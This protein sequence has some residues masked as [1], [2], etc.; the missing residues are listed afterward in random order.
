M[1]TQ[2]SSD[3]LDA[4]LKHSLAAEETTKAHLES[5]QKYVGLY[6]R[7][8]STA[9]S[10]RFPGAFRSWS[11]LGVIRLESVKPEELKGK[12]DALQKADGESVEIKQILVDEQTLSVYAFGLKRADV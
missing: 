7:F 8:A 9:T 2:N 10:E 1:S 12:L 6:H 5:A 3:A 11:L 4:L